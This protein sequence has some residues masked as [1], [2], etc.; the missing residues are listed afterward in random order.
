MTRRVA[1]LSLARD[2]DVLLV[3]IVD[4]REPGRLSPPVTLRLEGEAAA[5]LRDA[6][7]EVGA[8]FVFGGVTARPTEPDGVSA[9][10]RHLVAS[11]RP[12]VAAVVVGTAGRHGLE[13]LDA[14]GDA[15]LVHADGEVLRVPAVEGLHAAERLG[16]PLSSAGMRVLRAIEAPV[17]Q[18]TAMEIDLAFAALA[19]DADMGIEPEPAVW[20]GGDLDGYAELLH[21]AET[22]R[23]R[24]Q[25]D[26]A[27]VLVDRQGA[28]CLA[29]RGPFMLHRVTAW[30]PAVRDCGFN[31]PPTEPGLYVFT[32]DHPWS[33][34]DG[35]VE[36]I[37]EGIDGTYVPATEAALGAVGIT[38]DEVC[39]EAAE[40]GIGLDAAPAPSPAL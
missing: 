21:E 26:A 6:D 32:G 18:G 13:G 2:E 8:V 30:G 9:A 3:R 35:R 24:T 19:G 16:M 22:E 4:G 17:A 14:T 27:V 37:E 40:L 7:V 5:R 34:G 39:L 20:P 36:P 11:L 28:W 12:A 15:Y 10:A 38:M 25:P 33:Y 31:E 29:H 1:A 23:A